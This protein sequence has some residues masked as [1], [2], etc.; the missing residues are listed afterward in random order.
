MNRRTLLLL[1]ATTK[2]SQQFDRKFPA[3]APSIDIAIPNGSIT[4]RA[5]NR[6]DIHVRADIE[7]SASIPEDLQL[8]MREVRLEPRLDG[9]TFRIQ[10]ETPDNRRWTH[11]SYR[12]NLQVDLPS[13]ARLIVRAING[14]VDIAYITPPTKDIYVKNTNGEIALA[15][16]SPL[17]ADFQMTTRNGNIFTAFDMRNIPGKADTQ[18]TD[19][20]MKRIVSRNRYAGGRVG[21][22]GVAVQLEGFNG[23][24]RILDRKA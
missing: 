9:D 17:H 6:N 13:T 3:T 22:G 2:Q 10:V 18:V 8:A 5:S 4:V 21:N 19:N 20:G 23:D 24:I 1:L 14:N 15:F 7:Y 11:Y 12:H 16:P